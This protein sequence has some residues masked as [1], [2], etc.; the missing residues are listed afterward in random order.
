VLLLLLVLLYLLSGFPQKFKP[1]IYFVLLLMLILSFVCN[2]LLNFGLG[3]SFFVELQKLGVQIILSLNLLIELDKLFLPLLLLLFKLLLPN[4]LESLL[5][6]SFLLLRRSLLFL[7]LG[8]IFY[9]LFSFESFLP[10]E[11]LKRFSSIGIEALPGQFCRSM[12]IIASSH[13]L[14]L[15]QFPNLETHASSAAD[16]RQVVTISHL[17]NWGKSTR[18][19]L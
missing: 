15:L 5:S 1:S 3:L 19:V 17:S 14:V 4:D 6:L 11:F 12:G 18:D 7:L 9:I 2:Y 13:E 10:Q 8:R 16:C